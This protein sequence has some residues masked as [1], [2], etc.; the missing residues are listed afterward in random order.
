MKY[1]FSKYVVRTYKIFDYLTSMH[2]IVKQAVYEASSFLVPDC[3]GCINFRLQLLLSTK[4]NEEFE[5]FYLTSEEI[6]CLDILHLN[7]P[8]SFSACQLMMGDIAAS[9]CEH[10]EECRS[11]HAQNSF[12]HVLYNNLWHASPGASIILKNGMNDNLPPN[13]FRVISDIEQNQSI[14]K[15]GQT[16]ITEIEATSGNTE[17]SATMDLIMAHKREYMDNILK[18]P[19]FGGIWTVLFADRAEKV[20]RR[21]ARKNK[22][23]LLP[24]MKNI[25]MV[26]AGEW[27]NSVACSLVTNTR[28][29]LYECKVLVSNLF[30]ISIYFV[31]NISNRIIYALFGKLMFLL[32]KL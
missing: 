3:T 8:T 30:N 14:L 18:S 6:K 26:A 2:P 15:D 17:S 31:I 23:A 21:L 19:P 11:L 27:T 12:Q 25:H 4:P 10:N 28:V 24:V 20:I 9:V 5:E 29:V 1:F 32:L 13:N 7:Y 16:E 22:G